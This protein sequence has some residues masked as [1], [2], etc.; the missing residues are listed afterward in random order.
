M[1]GGKMAARIAGIMHAI[2]GSKFFVAG[3]RNASMKALRTTVAVGLLL[4]PGAFRAIADQPKKSDE[5]PAELKV[6]ERFVGTWKVEAIFKPSAQDPKERRETSTSRFELTLN[7]WFVMERGKT[8]DD[9]EDL[10]ILTFNAKKKVFRRW[11]FDSDGN[12]HEWTGKWDEKSSTLTWTGPA[13]DGITTVSVWK[14]TDKD[15]L[16]WTL[17]AKDKEGK[18]VVR[19]EGKSVRQK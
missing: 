15:T 11:Y 6:L 4:V 1:T 12:T 8:T 17:T 9:D 18:V 16:D 5:K 3:K 2:T 13:D 19:I 7:G 10:Q 14:L